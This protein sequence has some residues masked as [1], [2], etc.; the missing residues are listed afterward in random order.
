MNSDKEFRNLTGKVQVQMFPEHWINLN[1]EVGKHPVLGKILAEQGDRDA[2]VLLA[3]IAAFCGVVLDDTYTKQDIKELC[4]L[5][6]RKLQEAR[7]I[8]V[9]VLK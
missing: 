9:S 4:E 7:I 5:L 3:E 2:Y 6:T 1:V 8:N